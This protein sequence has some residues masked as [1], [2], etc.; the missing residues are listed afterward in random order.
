V[1]REF[2][3]Q[4]FSYEISHSNPERVAFMFANDCTKGMPGF[5]QFV[6]KDD[7]MG[8]ITDRSVSWPLYT[9]RFAPSSP[10]T[11]RARECDAY[12]GSSAYDRAHFQITRT[13]RN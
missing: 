3:C 13:D 5:H 6:L 1:A 2:V 9:A 10:S 11:N 4:E 7:E 12:I 8:F